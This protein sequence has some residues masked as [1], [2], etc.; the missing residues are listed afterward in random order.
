[1]P[2]SS[3]SSS[4]S[5][6]ACSSVSSYSEEGGNGYPTHMHRLGSNGVPITPPVVACAV[7][8]KKVLRKK[9]IAISKKGLDPREVPR[10]LLEPTA[11]HGFPEPLVPFPPAVALPIERKRSIAKRLHAT[12]K[13]MQDE[14]QVQVKGVTQEMSALDYMLQHLLEWEVAK[15]VELGWAEEKEFQT[16]ETTWA[17]YRVKIYHDVKRVI[18]AVQNEERLLGLRHAKERLKAEDEEQNARTALLKLAKNKYSGIQHAW[19]KTLMQHIS[20]ARTLIQ[21]QGRCNAKIAM[22][23]MRTESI[24]RNEEHKQERLGRIALERSAAKTLNTLKHS[25]FIRAHEQKRANDMAATQ[26]PPSTVRYTLSPLSASSPATYASTRN[27]TCQQSVTE[28][29]EEMEEEHRRALFVHMV[30]KEEEQRRGV[31]LAEYSGFNLVLF[32]RHRAVQVDEVS[33]VARRA[34]DRARTLLLTEASTL[35]CCQEEERA[36]KAIST[37]ATDQLAGIMRKVHRAQHRLAKGQQALLKRH[38][39]HQRKIKQTQ[40]K[41]LIQQGHLLH[42]ITRQAETQELTL[43]EHECREDITAEAYDAFDRLVRTER[44][45]R[46]KA[47][48]SAERTTRSRVVVKEAAARKALKIRLAR[49]A[50]YIERCNMTFDTLSHRN[51]R[52]ASQ[53]QKSYLYHVH[54]NERVSRAEL[55]K[56]EYISRLAVEKHFRAGWCA[57]YERSAQSQKRAEKDSAL[58]AKGAQPLVPLKHIQQLDQRRQQLAKLAQQETC[59]RSSMEVEERYLRQAI[60]SEQQPELDEDGEEVEYQEFCEEGYAEGEGD[61]EDK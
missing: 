2:A 18:E 39:I 12:Q 58:R 25:L 32:A 17:R 27:R 51:Q 53:Q 41:A 45:V 34:K 28:Y 42:R 56:F 9:K 50:D 26:P 44:K 30:R 3:V 29:C 23:F 61:S 20:A 15:R 31:L 5:S 40:T 21:R 59:L 48:G 8:A 6:D 54:G 7:P 60:A 11:R 10:S 1:M 24:T 14:E 16:F 52:N 46:Y 55:A 38:Q 35:A 49:G 57:A 13:I 47:F 22:N 36:R 43:E 4:Y 37:E 19:N 33:N